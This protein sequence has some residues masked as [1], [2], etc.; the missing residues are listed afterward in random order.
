MIQAAERRLADGTYGYCLTCGEAI[1]A[2][3]LHANPIATRCTEC[4]TRVEHTPH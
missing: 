1:P 4:Q 3:R 2:T